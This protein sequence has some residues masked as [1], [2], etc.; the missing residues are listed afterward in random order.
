ML[1][2]SASSNPKQVSTIPKVNESHVEDIGLGFSVQ[3]NP[4]KDFKS[5]TVKQSISIAYTIYKETFGDNKEELEAAINYLVIVWKP[6]AWKIKGATIYSVNGKKADHGRVSGLTTSPFVIEVSAKSKLCRTS[7]VH[8]LVHVFL[9][10]S[11][12]NPDADHEGKKYKGWTKEHTE[13]IELTN[14]L[15]CIIEEPILDLD[16]TLF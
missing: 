2:C 9:W 11:V 1:S 16:Q 15:L 8:E 14:E 12:G 7:L 13:Y 3:I 6:S 4:P 10:H 5:E